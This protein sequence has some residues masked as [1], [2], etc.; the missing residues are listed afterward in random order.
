MKL[1]FE[2]ILFGLKYF[3]VYSIK[4]LKWMCVILILPIVVYFYLKR[5]NNNKEQMF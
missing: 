3:C 2:Y 1:F 5:K 4:I